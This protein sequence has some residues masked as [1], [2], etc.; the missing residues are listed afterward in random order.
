MTSDYIDLDNYDYFRLVSDYAWGACGYVTFDDNKQV[1][2]Y[3]K[4]SV[5]T[6]KRIDIVP[7]DIFP[8]AKYIRFC[9]STNNLHVYVKKQTTLITNGLEE[10][11]E[12]GNVLYQVRGGL[13]F[14]SY[15][16]LWE[17]DSMVIVTLME[18]QLQ[19]QDYVML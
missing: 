8:T 14:Y 9:G 3:V 19:K 18:N 16:H 1:L 15:S 4:D 2:S 6:L 17:M 12:T 10:A 11:L 13:S 7:Q 5:N